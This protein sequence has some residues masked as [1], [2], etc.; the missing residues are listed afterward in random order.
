VVED[1]FDALPAG[2][3]KD[4]A[5][6]IIFGWYAGVVEKSPTAEAFTY[7]EALMYLRRSGFDGPNHR[8]SIRHFRRCRNFEGPPSWQ[9]RFPA[10]FT[11]RGARADNP[12]RSCRCRDAR[13]GAAGRAVGSGRPFVFRDD[14]HG[15]RHPNVPA[16]VYVAARAPD[17]GEDY[18]DLARKFPTPPAAQESLLVKAAFIAVEP[19]CRLT[20]LQTDA[21]RLGYGRSTRFGV[22][23]DD[24]PST[25]V[26]CKR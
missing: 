10:S 17:A 4:T 18:T 3:V 12:T 20:S 5:H 1:F 15:C 2:Q 23:T 13:A 16:V 11:G 19:G 25:N 9:P 26:F 22:S 24:G 6:Q 21:F 7:E 14:R 8:M